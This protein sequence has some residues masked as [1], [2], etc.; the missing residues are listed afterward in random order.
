MACINRR[1]VFIFI[2]I[3]AIFIMQ[4]L[5]ITADEGGEY[6]TER[7]DPRTPPTPKGNI[8]HG[9]FCDWFVNLVVVVVNALSGTCQDFR[10]GT[11]SIIGVGGS[12]GEALPLGTPFEGVPPMMVVCLCPPSYLQTY[13][14]IRKD[15][16]VV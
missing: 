6:K 4:L 9:S 12:V 2:F 1:S 13:F 14:F 10:K 3:A 16:V 5:L 15:E 8:N 11:A 7:Y